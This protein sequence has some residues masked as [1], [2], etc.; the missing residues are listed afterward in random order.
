MLEYLH[1][2]PSHFVL[3]VLRITIGWY[4][5]YA[6]ITK[7]LNPNWSAAGFLNNAK[8]FPEFYAWF[9]QPD[10]LPWINMLNEWGLTLVGVALIL[11]IGVRIAS[12]S[13][14]ALLLLYYFPVLQFPYVKT[15]SYYLVDEHIIISLLLLYFAAVRAGRTWGLERWCSNLPLCSRFPMLR[16]LIG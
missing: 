9:T 3:F 4:F 2:N 8:T 15:T 10:I 12:I 13:G 5:F 16:A 6:G 7:V 11:G 1:M 14:I